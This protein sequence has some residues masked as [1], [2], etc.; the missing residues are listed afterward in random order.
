MDGMLTSVERLSSV[1]VMARHRLISRAPTVWMRRRSA[2][3]IVRPHDPHLTRI[4]VH[5]RRSIG[6][7]SPAGT[8]WIRRWRTNALRP[9][10]WLGK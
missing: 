8:P 7:E 10:P 6:A 9:A 5:N 3:W 1:C 4:A 2:A